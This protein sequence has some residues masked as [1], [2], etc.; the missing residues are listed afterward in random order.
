[1]EDA[2][3]LLVLVDAM[4]NPAVDDKELFF[5]PSEKVENNSMITIEKSKAGNIKL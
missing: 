1:M 2:L 3:P 4:L 5:F